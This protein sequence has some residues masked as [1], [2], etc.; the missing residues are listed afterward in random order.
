VGSWRTSTASPRSALPF[1][2]AALAS[3]AVLGADSRWLVALGPH[4]VHALPFATA[5]T[6]GW[7]DV[8]AL[9]QTVLRGLHALLGD[10][11]LVLA[12]LA[13]AFAA[14]RLLP[15]GLP[16]GLALLAAVPTIAV[17][18]AELFSLVLFPA[19]LV[20]L[21]RRPDRLWLCVP[22]VALWSN[23]H[24]SVL[25]GLA[26]L[27]VYVAVERR[28][29]WPVGIAA[30][31]AA[32]L[33]P[34]LWHTPQYYWGVARNETARRGV[35]LWEPLGLRRFDV[36][37]ALCVLA[38]IAIASRRRAWHP[39][40]AVACAGLAVATIHSARIGTWLAFV[41]SYPAARAWKGRETRATFFLAPALAALAVVGVV[42]GPPQTG[43]PRL[44]DRAARTGAAVLAE[45]ITAE[46]VELAG[47]RVWVADPIDAFRR[48]DQRLYLDWLDGHG[49]GAVAHARYVLVDANGT[50]GRRAARDARLRA[51]A[52]DNGFVLYVVTTESAAN[53]RR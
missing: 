12:Q 47:G 34:A 29:A 11:G 7:H 31:V 46:Q 32:C 51:V 21:E 22:L 33:T 28:R 42:L 48:A 19:L 37:L 5:P 13:A 41:A 53:R 27:W 23:L 8:P 30:T 35:G 50:P 16:G 36:L 24:G 17:V 3:F 52:H 2:A 1:A 6:S 20:L 25:V 14:F 15:R 9:A 40:E 26:L 4:V 10:R 45:P 18:R 43:S 44:A 38:L 49:D 39:W